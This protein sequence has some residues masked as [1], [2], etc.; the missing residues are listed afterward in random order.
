LLPP[1]AHPYN[2]HQSAFT[3]EASVQ[4]TSSRHA[5]AILLGIIALLAATALAACLLAYL[6]WLQRGP[7]R[8]SRALALAPSAGEPRVDV[9]VPV[10]NEAPLIG[11]KL[12]N[13]G[14]LRYPGSHLRIWIVD[15]ASSDGTAET[16]QQW[17]ARDD[18][19][20]LLRL[21]VADKTAQV[22]A[23][24]ARGS[25]EW[26][27][28]TDG[29]ARLEP[30]TLAWLVAAGAAD[31]DL[32]AVGTPV[33]PAR[34]HPLE[35]LHW[36]ISNHL[37][38]WESRRGCASLVTAPC[39]LFRRTLLPSFPPDVVAD[40]AHVALAAAAAGRR[41]GLVDA[42]V[43]ELRS[44]TSLADLLRHK[45]RKTDAYLREIFRFLPRLGAMASPA[46]EV[47]LWRLVQ[48]T[49]AP[50]LAAIVLVALAGWLLTLELGADA[51]LVP[52]A[53]LLLLAGAAAVWRPTR[54]LLLG[55]LLGALLLAILLAALAACPF[56][57]Q[58]ACYPRLKTT[59]DLE[60]AD[61]ET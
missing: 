7:R 17:I 25:A 59:P 47:F 43:T 55:A 24:L 44:P 5:E 58:T 61:A 4:A 12:R 22:N 31:P 20:T 56:S 36:A 30:T 14:E 46:R 57:R 38:R 35:R 16:T 11:D 49:L 18:R 52:A 1:P 8:G 50:V 19:F 26:I 39:Y 32:A 9:I 13:L 34:A 28:V 42:A 21:P 53:G 29:D 51:L 33:Q 48:M 60:P 27:M 15:G 2:G 3:V 6:G 23:A 45:Q 10:H 41:V 54:N 40:D 37:R